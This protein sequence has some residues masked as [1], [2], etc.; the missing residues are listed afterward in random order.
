MI[1]EAS[2]KMLAQEGG[3]PLEDEVMFPGMIADGGQQFIK[4]QGVIKVLK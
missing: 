4:G 2:G 3:E 1:E